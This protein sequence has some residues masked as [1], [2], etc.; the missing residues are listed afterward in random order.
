MLG[1]FTPHTS[2]STPHTSG[3]CG[4]VAMLVGPDAPLALDPA[5]RSVYSDHTYVFP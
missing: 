3:G 5:W 2:L 1:P 4:A